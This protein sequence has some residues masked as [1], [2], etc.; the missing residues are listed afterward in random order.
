MQIQ[1]EVGGDN[2]LLRL[3]DRVGREGV[4]TLLREGTPVAELRRLPDANDA[5]RMTIERYQR[6]SAM[7]ADIP[8]ARSNGAAL[9]RQMRD[10]ENEW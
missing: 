1:V 2:A 3:V 5:P 10:A 6:L 9:V 4:V 8:A 7:T